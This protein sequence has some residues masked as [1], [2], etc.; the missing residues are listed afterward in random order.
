MWEWN[1]TDRRDSSSGFSITNGGC[2]IHPTHYYHDRLTQSELPALQ[3]IGAFK[4]GE[5]DKRRRLAP[6]SVAQAVCV[7]RVLLGLWLSIG[8]ELSSGRRSPISPRC[9]ATPI[10]FRV[11]NSIARVTSIWGKLPAKSTY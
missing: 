6:I 8:S 1:C 9:R 2:P 10:S 3:G 5:F 7:V 4:N 11:A